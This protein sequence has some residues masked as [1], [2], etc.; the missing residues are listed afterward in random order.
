M[1]SI[2]HGTINANKQ[3]L[4]FFKV[5]HMLLLKVMHYNILHY[6]KRYLI[7]LLSYSLW[8]E[9]HYITFALLFV[10]WAGLAQ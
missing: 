5:L 3:L 2:L 8:K 10:T 1:L 7:A 6:P 4:F 9:M